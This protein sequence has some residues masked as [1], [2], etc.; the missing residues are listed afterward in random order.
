MST[1]YAIN[2]GALPPAWDKLDPTALSPDHDARVAELKSIGA[3]EAAFY[4]RA[5]R[6]I[7]GA[8]DLTEL[9]E[10]H[11]TLLGRE[12]GIVT[13][14]LVVLPSLA[15]EQRKSKGRAF[16]LIKRWLTELEQARRRALEQAAE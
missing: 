13:K 10:R 11:T 8:P 16:N 14:W 2:K 9:K 6:G 1:A 15:A 12:R 7:A 5:A 4:D 3:P